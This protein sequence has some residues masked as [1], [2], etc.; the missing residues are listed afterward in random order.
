[1]SALSRLCKALGFKVSG[2]DASYSETLEKLQ[3]DDVF[4]YAG[5]NLEVVRRADAVVYTAAVPEDDEELRAAEEEGKIII[6]RGEFLGL[7]AAEFGKTVAVAGTHGKTTVTALTAL[8]FKNAGLDFT[9]HIGGLANDLNGNYYSTGK[10]YF[11]TE[12]CEYRKNFLHLNPDCAVVLNVEQDHPDCYKSLR[13]LYEAFDGFLLNCA[14]RNGRII[15]NGDCG[16]YKMHKCSYDNMRTF[17][18]GSTNDCYPADMCVRGGKYSFDIYMDNSKYAH[19]DSNM[20]GRHNV[21]NAL[22]LAL[23]SEQFHI[24]KSVLIRTLNT[25]SGVSRRFEEIKTVNGARVFSDYAHHPDEIAATVSAAREA[26]AERV[27]LYFQPHTFSRTLKYADGFAAALAGA[28]KVTVVKTYPARETP[29]QGM[30]GLELSRRVSLRKR[31]GYV[32]SLMAVASDIALTAREGDFIILTGAGDID[33]VRY[34][35]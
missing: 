25:F 14:R 23:I 18:F 21:L 24:D 11:V 26:G 6:E 32:K 28:D 29:D 27:V 4:C 33:L 19:I 30:D 12:A 34:L 5:H 2:S 20:Y 15:I 7:A 13:E 16:Y 35:I 1:M 10:E 8:L 31:C 22:A 3:E 17:G 9:A